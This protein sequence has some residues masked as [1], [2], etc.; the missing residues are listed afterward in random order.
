M[1]VFTLAQKLEL[2]QGIYIYICSMHKAVLQIK[3]A[4]LKPEKRR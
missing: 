1:Q 3:E 4:Y 2:T